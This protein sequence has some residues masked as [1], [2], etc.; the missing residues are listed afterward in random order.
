[1]QMKTPLHNA[2]MQPSPKVEADDSKHRLLQEAP[3]LR[4]T[5]ILENTT[6][7]WAAF[8][9]MLPIFMIILGYAPL[10]GQNQDTLYVDESLA[11]EDIEDDLDS[12]DYVYISPW[13]VWPMGND[14]FSTI[15]PIRLTVVRYESGAAVYLKFN[16]AN[17]LFYLSTLN[18]RKGF[19]G[20]SVFPIVVDFSGEVL[21]SGV[22]LDEDF[23]VSWMGRDIAYFTTKENV[24]DP[25]VLDLPE[26]IFNPV[27]HW[28]DE[29]SG[30]DL[31]QFVQTR[32]DWHLLEK[33]WLL[34]QFLYYGKPLRD[35]WIG[36]LPPDPRGPVT[37]DDPP[38]PPPP[39]PSGGEGDEC[40]CLVLRLSINTSNDPED[41]IIHIDDKNGNWENVWE[42]SDQQSFSKAGKMWYAY[43]M[44]GPAKYN[45][46][47]IDSPRCTNGRTYKNAVGFDPDRLEGKGE[48]FTKTGG[49][50]AVLKYALACIGVESFVPSDCYCERD[51]SVHVCYK[52]AARLDA[53]SEIR[54]G[55]ICR[56]GRFS[57]AYAEEIAFIAWTPDQ[58]TLDDYEVL[59]ANRWYAGSGCEQSTNWGEFLAN[60]ALTSLYAFKALK[61]PENVIDYALQVY[62]TDKL[63]DQIKTLFSTKPIENNPTSSCGLAIAP[64][65]SGSVMLD[66][67]IPL[68][69]NVNRTMVVVLQSSSLLHVE[70]RGRFKD[71]N[72]R[73]LSAYGLTGVIDR[74]EPHIVGEVCCRTGHA[75][76]NIAGTPGFNGLTEAGLSSWVRSNFQARAVDLFDEIEPIHGQWGYRGG[77]SRSDCRLEIV[78][79][80]SHDGQGFENYRVPTTLAELSLE[81][82]GNMLLVKNGKPGQDWRLAIM[83]INGR[84]LHATAG[85]TTLQEWIDLSGFNW[86]AGLYVGFLEGSNHQRQ[87]LKIIKH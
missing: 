64:V 18:Y 67:C 87:V 37:G 46:V 77:G 82:H 65:Q 43:G 62:Y 32:H 71:T 12:I 69:L 25:D 73:V 3:S 31:Y 14:T 50:R 81:Q 83:D 53:R 45:Q 57:R 22:D 85:G 54:G 29:P 27:S 41:G 13:D 66:N 72:A 20:S 33:T 63:A 40:R 84:T 4:M 1:M 7:F 59:D 70:G 52:Y 44:R 15:N 24:E 19:G 49:N 17:P 86:P 36:T 11:E 55:G 42:V 58:Q 78:D 30:M 2:I 39:G 23:Y 6:G 38:P 56:N 35:E 34:Q 5:K 9:M 60:V 26:H 28:L 21:I 76:Y 61:K 75:V 8:K 51:I 10:P 48:E 68:P 79:G 16:T 47:W 74:S 80:R